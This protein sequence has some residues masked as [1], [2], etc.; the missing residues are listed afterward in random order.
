M[1][2]L[3]VIDVGSAF[4]DF[5]RHVHHAAAKSS[6]MSDTR[7]YL[8]EPNPIYKR[9]P[10][11][12]IYKKNH[13]AAALV[14]KDEV[15]LELNLSRSPEMSSV[16]LAN[17][18]A[19]PIWSHHKAG[20]EVTGKIRVNGISLDTLISRVEKSDEFEHKVLKLD[21]QGEDIAVLTNSSK[22]KKFFD[23]VIIEVSYTKESQLMDGAE[24]GIGKSLQ[25]LESKGFSLLAAAPNGGGEANLILR[26]HYCSL[27]QALEIVEELDLL[28]NPVL[29]FKPTTRTYRIRILIRQLVY[30]FLDRLV[31]I[32]K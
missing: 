7:I 10:W 32:G 11:G 1:G 31:H 18:L 23:I 20:M 15:F 21:I 17:P 16:L 30:F 27:E 14:A 25:L 9:T 28:A 8:V 6:K 5:S 12:R 13:I 19:S 3:L 26:S 2:Q 29:K 24:E 22:A 4:G